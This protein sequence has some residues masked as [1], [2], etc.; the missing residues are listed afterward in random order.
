M[1]SGTQTAKKYYGKSV[2]GWTVHC[3]SNIFGLIALGWQWSWS[4]SPAKNARPQKLA[5]L[6]SGEANQFV[7]SPNIWY[8]CNEGSYNAGYLTYP[9]GSSLNKALT[10]DEWT[11]L[12]FRFQDGT[13]QISVNGLSNEAGHYGLRV[14]TKNYNG[15]RTL[16]LE[17]VIFT[18]DQLDTAACRR[19]SIR[20]HC[21]ALPIGRAS[22][23][24]R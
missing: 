24:M 23:A 14:W 15:R 13:V 1:E 20:T 12:K 17:D 9:D 3:N 7:N 22:A 11:V 8:V 6:K 2:E 5:T 21:L 16:Y 4:W 18:P 10:A 19:R